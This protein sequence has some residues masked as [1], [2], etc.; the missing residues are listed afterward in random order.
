MIDGADH[1][2]ADGGESDDQIY[3]LTADGQ[4][5]VEIMGGWGLPVVC[6]LSF[7]FA[8]VSRFYF[9]ET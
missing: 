9:L 4:R 3:N 2:L 8:V 5:M 7:C 6:Q 1:S